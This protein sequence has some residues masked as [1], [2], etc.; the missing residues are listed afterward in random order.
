MFNNLD[1]HSHAQKAKV[2]S[3]KLTPNHHLEKNTKIQEFYPPILGPARPYKDD[4]HERREIQ[5]RDGKNGKWK[6]STRNN[7]V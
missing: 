6:K 7:N 4:L 1:A 3:Y 2:P 5:T